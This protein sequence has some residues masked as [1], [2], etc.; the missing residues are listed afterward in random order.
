LKRCNLFCN[1]VP[2]P[3]FV[4]KNVKHSRNSAQQQNVDKAVY[5]FSYMVSDREHAELV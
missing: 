1:Y 2:H 5:I 4:S 3:N